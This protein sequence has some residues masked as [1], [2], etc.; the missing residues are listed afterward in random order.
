MLIHVKESMWG[1]EFAG[2]G[3]LKVPKDN[4]SSGSED[5]RGILCTASYIS[6]T[7]GLTRVGGGGIQLE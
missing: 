3:E 5:W 7:R 4:S 6:V 2:A 1:T